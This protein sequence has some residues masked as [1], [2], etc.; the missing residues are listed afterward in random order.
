MGGV[1]ARNNPAKDGMTDTQATATGNEENPGPLNLQRV[2]LWKPLLVLAVFA[3]VLSLAGT[4]VFLRFKES[5]RI[6]MQNE[7]GG[8]AELKTGQIINWIADRKGDAQTLKDDSLFVTA[9]DHWLQQGG[10]EGETKQKLAGRLAS[11]Q[12]VYAAYG[13]TSITLFDDKFRLRLSTSAE[14]APTRGMEKARTP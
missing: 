14:E 11:L 8:I 9:I 3:F 1:S 7:L 4:V 6:N 10:R 13:Y 12:R 5:I 2:N